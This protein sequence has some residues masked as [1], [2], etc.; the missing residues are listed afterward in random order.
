MDKAELELKYEKLTDA[1]NQAVIVIEMFHGPVAWEIY[2]NNAPE[3]K[4]IREILESKRH[5]PKSGIILEKEFIEADIIQMS[6]EVETSW[7]DFKNLESED[8]RDLLL[9]VMDEVPTV[10]TIKTWSK[11]MI[12]EAGHWAAALH[13]YS[14]DNNDVKV[15]KRPD[16]V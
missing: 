15:P 13:L 3:M 5:K 12:G 9:L 2:Y 11:K 10:E 6:G 16:F 1:L 14:S 8:V 4:M 7:E